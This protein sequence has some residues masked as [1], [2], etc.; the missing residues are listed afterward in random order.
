MRYALQT[1]SPAALRRVAQLDHDTFEMAQLHAQ[2]AAEGFDLETEIRENVLSAIAAGQ[3]PV[4]SS[5]PR[6]TSV[7]E[8]GEPVTHVV[9]DALDYDEVMAELMALL[10]T[11][12]GRALREA[13]ASKWAED[14]EGGIR[15]AREEALEEAALE[16]RS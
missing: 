1:T 11:E 4:M 2:V 5:K 3:G 13:I 10:K 8:T 14:A 6:G 12:A 9:Y 15:L 7:V 16:A